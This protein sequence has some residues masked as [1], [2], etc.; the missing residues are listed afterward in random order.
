M[1]NAIFI[2]NAVSG[3]LLLFAKPKGFT[4][5]DILDSA[6]LISLSNKDNPRHRNVMYN[7]ALVK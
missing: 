3:Y 6:D 5:Y 7:S 4:L 2:D 1:E